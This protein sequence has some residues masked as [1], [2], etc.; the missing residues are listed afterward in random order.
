MKGKSDIDIINEL[1]TY[2]EKDEIE[3]ANSKLDEV[4]RLVDVFE[5]LSKDYEAQEMIVESDKKKLNL[6]D[7]KRRDVLNKISTLTKG[8]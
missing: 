1:L 4:A 2:F 6:I 3:V 5:S 8:E 7:S